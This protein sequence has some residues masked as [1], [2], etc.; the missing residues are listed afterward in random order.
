MELYETSDFSFSLTVALKC[1]VLHNSSFYRKPNTNG[2]ES[3]RKPRPKTRTCVRTCKGLPNG[4]ISRLVSPRKSQT[5]VNFTHICSINNNN[6]LAINLYRLALGGQT[7]NIC[8]DLPMNLSSTN[9]STSRCKWVA[10]SWRQAENLHWHASP[11]GQA[12]YDTVWKV[13]ATIS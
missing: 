7:E 4:L 9:V 12:A 1:E 8:V 13:P 5:A 2:L 11:F 3:Q 10:G 6:W